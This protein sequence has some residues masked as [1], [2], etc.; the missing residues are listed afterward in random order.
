MK[1]EKWLVVF[2]FL[3]LSEGRSWNLDCCG[4]AGPLEKLA[5]NTSQTTHTIG[6][7]ICDLKR[8]V[9]FMLGE[10]IDL[11]SRKWLVNFQEF[12]MRQHNQTTG[13]TSVKNE[14]TI[15]ALEREADSLS[16]DEDNRWDCKETNSGKPH[17]AVDS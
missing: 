6:I 16:N 12:A 14:I 4:L 11:L 5:L 2:D 9:L 15:C 1:E 10:R 8:F 13:F 7:N 3:S 17:D